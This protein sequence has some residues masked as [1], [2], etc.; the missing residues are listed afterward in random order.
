MP[1]IFFV[2]ECCFMKSW[3][4]RIALL[5]MLNAAVPARASAA[6]PTPKP[7]W[8]TNY[9]QAKEIAGRDGKLLLVVFR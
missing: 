2:L 6:P 3:F 9:E 5:V 4:L 8:H 7:L 1:G